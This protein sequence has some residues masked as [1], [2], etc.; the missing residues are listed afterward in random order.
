MPQVGFG[1]LNAFNA[2]T[3]SPQV[4]GMTGTD[5]YYYASGQKIPLDADARR[6]WSTP[7][8]AEEQGL[9]QGELSDARDSR[10]APISGRDW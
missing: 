1:R 8:V 2:S 9:W 6:L 10:R 3:G 7:K 5:D 4:V